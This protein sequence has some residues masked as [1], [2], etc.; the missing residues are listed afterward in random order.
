MSSRHCQ[1][2]PYCILVYGH[3]VPLTQQTCLLDLQAASFNIKMV[4]LTGSTDV[5][6]YIKNITVLDQSVYGT[7]QAHQQ[8]NI[9]L[10]ERFASIGSHLTE[11]DLSLHSK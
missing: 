4:L 7:T 1:T 6:V 2:L 9:T 10:K 8:F 11:V 5:P 3:C